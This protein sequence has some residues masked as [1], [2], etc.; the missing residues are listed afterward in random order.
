MTETRRAWNLLPEHQDK[1]T[2]YV[3]ALNRGGQP[4]IFTH[5]VNRMPG[6]LSSRPN[7]IPPPPHPQASIAP[8]LWVQGGRHTRLRRRGWWYPIS[9]KY[10]IYTISSLRLHTIHCRF[11]TILSPS[12]PPPIVDTFIFYLIYSTS[13][14]KTSLWSGLT[15]C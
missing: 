6:F 3:K 8:L 15:D 2:F 1:E 14:Y 10:F 9:A 12:P 13:S 7:R 5:R 11:Y 4:H